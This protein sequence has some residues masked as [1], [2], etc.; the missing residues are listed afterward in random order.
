MANELVLFSDIEKMGMVIA[1]SN[2][3]GVK[4]PDQAI[5]L[6]L[7][8]QAEGLHPATAARDYH[9]I[10]GRPALKADAMLARFQAAGGTV[11]FT[12]Y[13]DARVAAEFS[14]PAGGTITVDWDKARAAAAGLNTDTWK[15]YPRA[16]LR[17]RVISEAIRTIYPGVLQGMYTP[18][19]VMDMQEIPAREEKVVAH[20]VL[21]SEEQVDRLLTECETRGVDYTKVSSWAVKKYGLL[22]ITAITSSQIE[23]VTAEIMKRPVKEADDA[24]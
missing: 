12:E 1:K 8:A 19:E 18:E 10:N 17:A 13:T 9:I 24:K 14:H 6:C 22:D 7:L 15:K 21:A 23:E 5:A 3:F 11:K 16:M 2:L 20:E 4:T